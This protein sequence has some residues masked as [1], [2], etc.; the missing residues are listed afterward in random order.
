[1][2]PLSAN[3]ESRIADI[4]SARAKRVYLPRLFFPEM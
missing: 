1:M 4:L 2:L 3:L